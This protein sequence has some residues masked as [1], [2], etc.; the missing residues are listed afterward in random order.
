MHAIAQVGTLEELKLY[1]DYFRDDATLHRVNLHGESVLHYAAAGAH[2]DVVEFLIGRGLDV[3]AVS[4]NGWTPLVCALMSIGRRRVS[5]S[6]DIANVLLRNG[7]CVDTV[8]AENWTPMHALASW[9]PNPSDDESGVLPLARELVSRGAILEAYPNVLRGK[10]VTGR[11]TV[12]GYTVC[13]KWGVKMQRFAHSESQRVK[14]EV[15]EEDTAP[16]M[17]ADRNKRVDVFQAI[18]DHW[19]SD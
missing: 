17:W 3:N 4:N 15:R 1:L 13:G 9:W 8:T 12:L 6:V 5:T 14:E 19:A 2:V 18:L 7:A 10:G 11:Y 16:H